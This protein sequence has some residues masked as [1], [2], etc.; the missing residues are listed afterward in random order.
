MILVAARTPS[1]CLNL[2][3]RS[4]TAVEVPRAAAAGTSN[5]EDDN[6]GRE[7]GGGSCGSRE[8]AMLLP[9]AAGSR[10]A[11]AAGGGGGGGFGIT[12]LGDSPVQLNPLL[13]NAEEDVPGG[14]RSI[15]KLKS[16]CPRRNIG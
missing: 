12:M 8:D 11:S 10:A 7:D 14:T 13:P 2:D 15:R 16:I 1:C 5:L 3:A 6:I 4:D 9:E